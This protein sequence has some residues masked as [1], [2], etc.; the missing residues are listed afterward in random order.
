MLI[1]KT[2]G[3]FILVLGMLLFPLTNVIAQEEE[4]PV[5]FEYAEANQTCLRCHGHATYN[6]YN[7]YADRDIRERMNP[8]LIVDSAKFYQMQ[9]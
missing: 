7:E 1:L 6:Y 5:E 4:A 9:S 2:R 8:Y 3:A